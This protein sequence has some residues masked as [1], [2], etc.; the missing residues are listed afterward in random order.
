MQ[1]YCRVRTVPWQFPHDYEECDG[2]A[3]L[4]GA[5]CEETA[6]RAPPLPSLLPGALLPQLSRRGCRATG[7]WS[8]RSSAHD[9]SCVLGT[10]ERRPLPTCA[11]LRVGS[12]APGELSFPQL[13]GQA[14]RKEAGPPG[15]SCPRWALGTSGQGQVC[16]AVTCMESYGR[17]RGLI[18]H[19]HV[20]CLMSP[21]HPALSRPASSWHTWS[22]WT[23]SLHGADVALSERETYVLSQGKAAS[24]KETAQDMVGLELRPWGLES[25]F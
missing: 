5:G 1:L 13:S 16:P 25:L 11:A 9:G 23:F 7:S 18:Q 15:I 2:V 22:V 24:E 4:V 3:D 6:R 21:E 19:A 17:S 14:Q 10:V 12:R 8:A 20:Q